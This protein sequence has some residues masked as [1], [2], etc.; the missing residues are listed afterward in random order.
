MQNETAF[1]FSAVV[2]LVGV[3]TLI[4]LFYTWG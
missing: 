2:A 4:W 3:P 1:Y